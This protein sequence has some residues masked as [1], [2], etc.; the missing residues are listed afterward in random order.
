[1][2]PFSSMRYPEFPESCDPSIPLAAQELMRK[3]IRQFA[4]EYA[5]KSQPEGL[6]DPNA[7]QDDFP[8]HAEP[9]GPLDLT[10]SR[11]THCPGL[12]SASVIHCPEQGEQPHMYNTARVFTFSSCMKIFC[13]TCELGVY[14]KIDLLFTC[15]EAMQG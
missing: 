2:C 14:F 6:E 10:V 4:I 15:Y 12:V 13:S 3:M 11:V 1:M 9:D 5:C 7:S 8:K